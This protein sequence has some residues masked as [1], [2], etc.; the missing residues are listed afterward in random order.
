MISWQNIVIGLSL[1]LFVFICLKEIQRNNRSRLVWRLVASLLA[2]I[3]LVGM[4]V[5]ISIDKKIIAPAKEA[6]LLTEGYNKDSVDRFIKNRAGDMPLY[7]TGTMVWQDTELTTLHI[8]GYGLSPAELSSLNNIP[9]VFHPSAVGTGITTVHWQQTLKTGEQLRIQGR[10]MNTHTAPVKILLEGFHTVLDSAHIPAGATTVFELNS[11]PKHIG[12]AVYTLM[13]V[14]NNDT[15]EKQPI[16]VEVKAVDSLKVL[17]LAA[18]PDFENKFLSKWLSENGCV[19]VSRARISKNKF[20]KTFV[21]SPSFRFDKLSAGL[22]NRFDLVVSDVTELAVLSKA[23]QSFVHTAIEENG[24]GL[25]VKADS[26][27]SVAAFYAAPFSQYPSTGKQQA[28]AMNI[29]DAIKPTAPLF[30]EQRFYIRYKPGTQPLVSDPESNIFV[31]SAIEGMG[32]IVFSTISNTYTWKLAGNNNDYT[33][34][35]S[36]L[37]QKAARKKEEARTVHIDDA[38]PLAGEPLALG[39][40]WNLEGLPHPF[41]GNDMLSVS[42]NNALPFQSVAQYWPSADGWQSAIQ[43][44]DK[45][46]QWYVYRNTDWKNISAAEKTKQT[47]Q[48]I[49][50]KNNTVRKG[51]QEEKIIHAAIPVFYFLL[52][53]ISC[54]GFLWVEKKL[55]PS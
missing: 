16:P 35:W 18:S 49:Y 13:A 1:L 47:F 54:C 46:Y 17:L 36:C 42:Q 25:I 5:P 11:I 30:A 37:L 53:F 3:S 19:V 39:I 20:V 29:K 28:A 9:L 26:I 51:M 14:T 10:F 45:Y 22:L 52:I 23:E 48:H 7:N 44:D 27:A 12:K 34:Y 43:L 41:I 55:S 40:A 31:S 2:V 32:K 21:N 38:L 50:Y 33:A 15:L 4:T 24:I 6:V 8:F